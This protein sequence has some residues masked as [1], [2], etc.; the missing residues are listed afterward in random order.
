MSTGPATDP[1][2]PATLRPA[3]AV[4]LVDVDPDGIAEL[5][6]A[7]PGVAGLSGGPF[8]AA[9]TYL[10]G[11]RVPGVR[12]DGPA[13]EVH[14]VA[15]YGPTVAEL[16]GQIRRALSGRVG[17]RRVDIVVEDLLDPAESAAPR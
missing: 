2:A 15:R 11:R 7:C 3:G 16:A 17:G 9:A 10:P 6:L 1:P 5:V 12:L 13:L 8:G 4:A 14:V